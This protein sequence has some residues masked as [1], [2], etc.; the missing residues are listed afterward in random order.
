VSGYRAAPHGL[1]AEGLRRRGFST[2]TLTRLRRAYKTIYRA[3]LTLKEAIAQLKEQIAECP[4]IGMMVD[5]LEKSSR[6]I[7][8]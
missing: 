3:N 6:G 2:E 7:V 1:N 4:E 5:F 8:R